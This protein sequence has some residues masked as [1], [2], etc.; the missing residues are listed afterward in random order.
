MRSV[1]SKRSANSS[2]KFASKMS[3]KITSML[4][5]SASSFFKMG[6]KRRSTSKAMTCFASCA[7]RSVNAPIPGP[8]SI[9]TVSLSISPAANIFVKIPGSTRKFCPKLFFIV[10]PYFFSICFVLLGVAMF[11]LF[12]VP[13]P[14]LVSLESE[15]RF[16]PLQH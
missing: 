9:T 16:Y 6:S 2:G 3:W 8:I 1:G 15:V 10:K 4:S 14:V 7:K 5:Y 13:T 12:T 11:L